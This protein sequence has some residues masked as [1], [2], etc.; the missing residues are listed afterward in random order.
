M[1]S[2]VELARSARISISAAGAAALLMLLL[3][4]A[5]A[6][7]P[8]ACGGEPPYR[9]GQILVVLAK[10]TGDTIEEVVTRN[11]GQASDVLGQFRAVRDLLA[12]A[13]EVDNLSEAIVYEVAVQVGSEEQA[14]ARYSAD[15][16]VYAAAVDR[17][18]FGTTSAPN[19]ATTAVSG[20]RLQIV[21]AGLLLIAAALS[22]GRGALQ[23]EMRG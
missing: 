19:T 14:A 16:A 15:P 4:E 1:T 13:G 22:L 20:P 6:A 8:L 11:G 3:T 10:S 23:A 21:F 7:D 2:F 12:P 18:T 5:A 17:E 9:C